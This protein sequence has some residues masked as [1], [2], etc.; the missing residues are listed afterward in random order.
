MLFQTLDDK[1]SC[2]GI[3]ADHDLFFDEESFPAPLTKTWAPAPYLRGLPVEY[4]S[5]YL[6]GAPVRERVPEYLQEDWEDALRRLEAFR[7][8][9]STAQVDMHENCFFDLVPTRFLRDFCE[10][11]NKITQHILATVKKPARYEY[12]KHLSFLLQ[13]IQDRPIS[14][15]KRVLNS[16]AAD[17]KLGRQA[18][19]IMD[20]S[21]YVK[22]N[23]FGTKTG[24]LTT[25][26]KTL[27]I[28]TLPAT[29]RSAIL[30]QN[31]FFVELDFNGAEVRTLLG[32]LGKD[33]PLGDV[34]KFHQEHIFQGK[35]TREQCKQAFFAWLYGSS[36]AVNQGESAML[37]TFYEKDNLLDRFWV[38]GEVRTPYRRC[39]AGVDKHHA[40]N[41]LVQSTAAELCLK[42]AL[43]IDHL[44][45]TRSQGSHVAFLIHDAIIIDLKKEDEDLLSSMELLMQSTNFGT[46]VV[47]RKKGKTL[48]GL[49]AF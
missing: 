2:V 45:R 8:S 31:D 3:Y 13:D 19:R 36:S 49:N 27:P 23:M 41:Y 40:L 17:P 26:P 39:M 44:L 12:Y 1:S 37:A 29:L 38:N 48:G 43:K 46:F 11:K 10:V 35:L 5:L 24:R 9:L 25:A 16:Y 14:L 6:E 30:P 22:Y 20:C 21:P 32:L 28:L 34:H 18:Q 15:N 42:Q 33:Q 47:N 4:A 7:R